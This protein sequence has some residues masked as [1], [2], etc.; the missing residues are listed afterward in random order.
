M[1][2]HI[3]GKAILL[4]ISILTISAC[5][6]IGPL[7]GGELSGKLGAVP[8][9]WLTLDDAEVVPLEVNGPYSVNIW[10]IGVSQGYYVAAGKGI[11]SKW[12]R[13]IVGDSA[14]RLRIAETIYELDAVQV[15]DSN[16]L[17]VV[18]EAYREKYELEASEDFPNAILYRLD[19]R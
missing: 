3:D 1:Q 14:V 17:D 11:E 2:A 5:E 16:E 8:T 4:L 18:L 6:P 7:P 12:S 19:A 15:D 10:G 13:K 9:S